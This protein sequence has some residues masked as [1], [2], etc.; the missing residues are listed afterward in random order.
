M[1]IRKISQ[2][3]YRVQGHKTKL[4]KEQALTKRTGATI[5]I[6]KPRSRASRIIRYTI[7]RIPNV[8]GR[9]VDMNEQKCVLEHGLSRTS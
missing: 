5:R 9:S 4:S 7:Q 2:K 8:E 1:H 6:M 3:T